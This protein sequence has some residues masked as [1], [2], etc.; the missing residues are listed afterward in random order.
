MLLN[1]DN[2]S[3]E[4]AVIHRVLLFTPSIRKHL[5]LQETYSFVTKYVPD[6]SPLKLELINI[7]NK[8]I[9]RK[10]FGEFSM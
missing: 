7:L 4:V 6:N 1:E 8:Y 3:R 9:V 5:N 10:D 2:Q